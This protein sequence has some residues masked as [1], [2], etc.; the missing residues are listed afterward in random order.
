MKRLICL[1]VFL[2]F[3]IGCS[4]T[5][6]ETP[7]PVESE[8]AALEDKQEQE[9]TSTM[10]ADQVEEKEDQTTDAKGS[11][12]KM[13]DI[14]KQIP[15]KEL[16]FSKLPDAIK[17]EAKK[18]QRSGNGGTKVIHHEGNTY[19]VVALGERNTGGFSVR[20]NDLVESGDQLTIMAEEKK[21]PKG[22][23]V[24]QV[25]SYP[26]TTVCIEGIQKWNQVDL[27][28]SQPNSK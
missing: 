17:P 20:V 5:S 25:I 15:Y 6:T 27:M 1:C 9:T 23:F 18:L 22:A 13:G 8:N 12:Q 16:T 4:N 26:I 2:F 14:S 21:P 24:P 19:I 3:M 7:Q 10:P 28:L 11:E